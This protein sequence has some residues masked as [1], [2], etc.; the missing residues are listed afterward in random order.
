M[1]K[2]RKIEI[3]IPKPCSED[4]DKMTVD[5]QG[6]FCS[7]CNKTVIDFSNYTDKELAA[8]FSK[9]KEK[10]CGNFYGT[11]LNR[12]IA[13]QEQGNA[14]FLHKVMIGASLAAGMA[15]SA[16]GQSVQSGNNSFPQAQA[17]KQARLLNAVNDTSGGDA[18]HNI[19][20]VVIDTARGS[21][22]PSV[23]I[24]LKENGTLIKKVVSS[25][26]GRF[27]IEVNDSLVGKT[28]VLQ[29]AAIN[30]SS[31]PVQIHIDK[32]P[33]K[34][35]V[36]VMDYL[37]P[38][39]MYRGDVEPQ[40]VYVIDGVKIQKEDTLPGQSPEEFKKEI[41]NKHLGTPASQEGSSPAQ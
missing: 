1:S 16:S 19:R 41:I 37:I 13:I 15:A 25:G 20:G 29:T 23:A 8:F 2:Q 6:K 4:W 28:I 14:S 33:I 9:T 12:L 17:Q 21:T 22:I 40:T 30:Y 36:L 26:D 18:G 27:S 10:V 32:L 35:V 5:E 3:S 31:A 38:Q 24:M 11:Q 34:N 39:I 7:H